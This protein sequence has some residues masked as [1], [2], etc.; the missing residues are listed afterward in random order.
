MIS[1][2]SSFYFS[3]GYFHKYQNPFAFS[4]P[5]GV[6]EEEAPDAA[7]LEKWKKALG[8]CGAEKAHV[9]KAASIRQGIVDPAPI[10]K[11]RQ[12]EARFEGAHNFFP[13]QVIATNDDGSVDIKYEDGD[14]EKAVP[15]H[16]V[17]LPEELQP[18][19]L[20]L[21][22]AVDSRHGGGDLYYP[23]KVEQVNPDGTYDL[24]YEDGDKEKNVRR[25]LMLAQAVHRVMAGER[26]RAE[27]L[28][29]R[30]MKIDDWVCN[31]NGKQHTSVFTR[32]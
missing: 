23:A 24:H 9:E 11:G 31:S 28:I 13:G 1:V 8:T 16:R 17:K 3:Q 29:K 2:S 25:P 15:R 4:A 19:T 7:A 5:Q 32:S 26:M 10:V 30:M 27:A 21:G 6:F 14:M 20:S 12:V 18:A 22:D